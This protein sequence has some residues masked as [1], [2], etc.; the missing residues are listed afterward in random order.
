MQT[1]E[2]HYLDNGFVFNIPPKSYRRRVCVPL[3]MAVAPGG[4]SKGNH[5]LYFNGSLVKE[6]KAEGAIFPG[7]IS[8]PATA[9]N[10]WNTY[11]EANQSVSIQAVEDKS[12]GGYALPS[13]TVMLGQE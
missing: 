12:E 5:K 7:G 10:S 3:L 11:I 2:I 1:E 8:S 4:K 9:C 13:I 6:A